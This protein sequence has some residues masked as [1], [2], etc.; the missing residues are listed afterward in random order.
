MSQRTWVQA[1]NAQPFRRPTTSASFLKDHSRFTP[2]ISNLFNHQ[3][4]FLKGHPSISK[5]V[6]IIC[7][8][9]QQVTSNQSLYDWIPI[10]PVRGPVAQRLLGSIRNL[11][12]PAGWGAGGTVKCKVTNPIQDVQKALCDPCQTTT[13][14]S[15]KHFLILF[16]QEWPVKEHSTSL[17]RDLRATGRSLVWAG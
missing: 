1:E 4:N 15:K 6:S 16:E 13:M 2:L 12:R 9:Y 5:N 17:W 11:Q 14:I 10:L 7:K 3:Y 8:R